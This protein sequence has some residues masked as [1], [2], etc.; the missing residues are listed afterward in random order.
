ML[1]PTSYWRSQIAK[2]HDETLEYD[3]DADEHADEHDAVNAINDAVI[4]L[5]ALVDWSVA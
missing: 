3:E 1:I 5:R 4:L 2:Q